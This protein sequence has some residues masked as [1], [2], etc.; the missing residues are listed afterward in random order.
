MSKKGKR[1]STF[2][3]PCLLFFTSFIKNHEGS[4]S[5]PFFLSGKLCGIGNTQLVFQCHTPALHSRYIRTISN[6][7]SYPAPERNYNESMYWQHRVCRQPW[8]YLS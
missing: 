5:D 7:I 1:L 8:R 4:E 6:I 3:Q 2:L